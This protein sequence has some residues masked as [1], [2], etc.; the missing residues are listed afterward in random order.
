VPRRF[1]CRHRHRLS[2]HT[3]S[4]SHAHAHTHTHT[5]TQTYAHTHMHTRMHP[6]FFRTT[7]ISSFGSCYEWGKSVFSGKSFVGPWKSS[8]CSINEKEKWEYIYVNIYKNT[9]I[10]IHKN[11]CIYIYI[12][13]CICIYVYTCIYMYIHI[14]KSA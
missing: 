4:H 7:T 3:H 1:T 5:H 9:C 2:T 10:C 11:I 14:S 6:H 13:A 12:Y 8:S